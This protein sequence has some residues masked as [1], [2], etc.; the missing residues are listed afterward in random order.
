MDRTDHAGHRERLRTRFRK[1]GLGGFAPHEVLEL[2][3]TYAIP[4]VDT[5]P[6][7]HALIRRFGSLPA[8]LE[9]SQAELEQVPGIGESASTLI[10]L[11]IP[12]FKAYEQ[13]KLL[14]R[15][16]L[17]TYADL[18]AYCRTLFLGVG[19]EQFYLLC[20]DAQ[21]KLLA[22]CL[23]ADGTPGEV[24]VA[25][26]MIL[27]EL[28]RRDAL[29]A[30]ITHNHPSGSAEPSREDIALTREIRQALQ[31]AGVRLYDHVLI[32][33]SRDYSFSLHHLLDDGEP[34]AFP[35]SEPIPLAADRPYQPR[36]RKT[37]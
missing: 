2:L 33:G 15:Q 3:L 18:E 7:A 12:V 10:R 26:R 34:I 19:H 22:T 27:Q 30:V 8:V 17:S 16:Q 9:A 23:M 37:K 29:G 4:R 20:F 6:V 5:N 24:A 11:M 31:S 35:V 13:D 32:A 25:P 21:M 14:P 28:L 36:R 1:E